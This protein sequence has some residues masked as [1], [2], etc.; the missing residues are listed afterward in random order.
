MERKGAFPYF[1]SQTLKDTPPI[2]ILYITIIEEKNVFLSF[3]F[4]LPLILPL[5]YPC[6]LGAA[7]AIT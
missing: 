4:L 7:I 2:F 6:E 1:A 3:S 5:S